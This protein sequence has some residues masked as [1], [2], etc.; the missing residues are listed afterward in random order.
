MEQKKKHHPHHT[1]PHPTPPTHPATTVAGS[2]PSIVSSHKLNNRLAVVVCLVCKR[3]PQAES[4]PFIFFPLKRKNIPKTR[5]K[6][7]GIGTQSRKHDRR[8]PG[9]L[10]GEIH[11]SSNLITVILNVELAPDIIVF[12]MDSHRSTL[13]HQIGL[14]RVWSASSRRCCTKRAPLV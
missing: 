14:P 11:V 8:S 12:F 4:N 10:A 5:S 6:A 2:I 13:D 7:R 3:R 9:H 1:P